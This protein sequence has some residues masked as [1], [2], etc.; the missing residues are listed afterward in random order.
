MGQRPTPASS[1]QNQTL[2]ELIFALK[3]LAQALEYMHSDVRRLLQDEGRDRTQSAEKLAEL[4]NKNAQALAVLPITISDR[5][6]KLVDRMDSNVDKKIDS[7]L[8]GVRE[9]IGTVQE[10]LIRYAELAGD[11]SAVPEKRA[12][13]DYTGKF[14]ITK[15]G[16]L[17]MAGKIPVQRIL[18][19]AKWVGLGLASVGGL[20]GLIKLFIDYFNR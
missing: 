4:C 9:T 17:K 16:E 8:R 2:L 11:K 20:T 18:T 6:E 10:R 15:A 19:I 1:G 7:V 14:E 3:G 12:E 13:D 5:V